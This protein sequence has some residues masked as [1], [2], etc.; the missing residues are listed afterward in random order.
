MKPFVLKTARFLIAPVVAVLWPGNA[1]GAEQSAPVVEVGPALY[2]PTLAPKVTPK[3]S[4]LLLHAQRLPASARHD[5]GELTDS[6]R[7]RLNATDSRSG[8]GAR[9]KRVKNGITR[10][11]SPPVGFSGLS[12]SLAS[13]TSAE[14]GGGLLEKLADGSL[15]WTAE[16]SSTGAGALR[17]Y[18]SQARLPQGSRVYVYGDDGEIQGP[19][20][21][22]AGTRPEGFWTNTIYSSS[23]SIEVRIPAGSNL[24][25]ATLRVGGLV[26]IVKSGT[27]TLQ[28][29]DDSCF[30]DATCVTVADWVN[31][32]QARNAV[33]QL[34]FVDQGSSFLCSGG[35]MNTANGPTAPYLL[36]AN[37]CFGFLPDGHTFNQA[38]ATSLEAVWQYKTATC[39]GPFPD[40]S[41]FPSTLGS[42]LLATGAHPAK[43]DYTF[44]QLSEE[45]PAN[46]VALGWTTAD[47]RDAAGLVLYRLS[48]PLNANMIDVDPQIFTREQVILVSGDQICSDAPAERFIYEKDIEGG[49][50]GGSSGSPAMLADLRVVGQEFGACGTNQTDDCDNINNASVDGAFSSTFPAVQQWLAPSNFGACVPDATTLCLQNNR[51]RVTAFWTRPDN[52]SGAGNGVSLTSDSGYFWFFSN[53]NIELIVK[54]LN[55]CAINSSYWVFAAGLTNVNVTVIVEDTVTGASQ[56]YLNPQSQAYQPLQDTAAFSCP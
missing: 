38:A 32:E 33:A 30:V 18:L 9:A 35:L 52:S 4:D 28:P 13:G 49:T 17:L 27:A 56:T 20:D 42:T 1:R 39:N 40:P 7:A 10:D 50:G 48:Y 23:I 11:V 16:F 5:L 53:T 14:M 44:V 36:T 26:H 54:V 19:Y 3:A 25:G 31:I 12:A 47:V 15:A 2:R 29:K 51:Y 24:E 43:S 21:F 46:S 8:P 45:P 6:E 41:L 55:G 37:H 34:N 22:A